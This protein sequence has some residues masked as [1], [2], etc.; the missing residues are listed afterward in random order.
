[1]NNRVEQNQNWEPRLN[2]LPLL[3]QRWDQNETIYLNMP[4]TLMFQ[5]ECTLHSNCPVM[6]FYKFTN[7]RRQIPGSQISVENL[8]SQEASLYKNKKYM[9]H[10]LDSVLWKISH[11]GNQVVTFYIKEELVL[12]EKRRIPTKP[13]SNFLNFLNI[14]FIQDKLRPAYIVATLSKGKIVSED[15]KHCV[16]RIQEHWLGLY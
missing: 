15:Q 16:K 14:N 8:H 11:Q 5:L 9:H 12:E 10:N 1:M 6:V 4:W 3:L 13:N 2:L 7:R